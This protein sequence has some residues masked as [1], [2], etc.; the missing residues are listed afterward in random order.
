MSPPDAVRSDAD[1]I[2]QSW[3]KG[4]TSSS[5]HTAA[6][7]LVKADEVLR[8][9]GG[10]MILPRQGQPPAVVAKIRYFRGKDFHGLLI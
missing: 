3:S 9:S 2:T 8:L 10:E 5:E 4:G 7:Y 1:F 6:R